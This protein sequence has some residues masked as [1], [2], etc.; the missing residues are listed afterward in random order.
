MQV[1]DR[2]GAIIVAAGSSTR[3]GGEDKMLIPMGGL[4]LI[5]HTIAAFAR[6]DAIDRITVV[7]SEK[8]WMEID[9]L[10]QPEKR[11][12]FSVVLG[13]ARRRDSVKAGLERLLECDYIVV[14]D[15]AR[16][17]VTPDLILAA[18]E[19][20]REYGAALCAIPVV[21]TVK[22]ADSHRLVRSTVSRDRLWLAQTPQAFRRDLLVRAHDLVEGDMTDDAAMIEHLSEPVK[23]VEGSIRNIKVTTPQDVSF[24]EAL[25]RTEWN[26]DR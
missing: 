2:I 8:N 23:I 22:R 11:R 7:A 17:F 20:A 16:P 26:G 13:G 18:I 25:L 6:C 4:P 9:N 14:H 12:P 24:A 1:H 3:M 10:V 21:D 5:A 19:G 15:G